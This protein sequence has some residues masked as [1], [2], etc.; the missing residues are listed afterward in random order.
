[1]IL[2]RPPGRLCGPTDAHINVVKSRGEIWTHKVE[3]AR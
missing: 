3:V 1:M 2:G